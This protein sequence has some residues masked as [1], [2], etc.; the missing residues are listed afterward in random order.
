MSRFLAHHQF[1]AF[2]VEFGAPIDKLLDVSRA[3]GYESLDRRRIAKACAGDQCVAF[4]Q[5]RIV[6][7]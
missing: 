2:A 7:V 6:I 1:A 4:V 5:F 3:L